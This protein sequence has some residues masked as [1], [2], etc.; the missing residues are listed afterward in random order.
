MINYNF[1]IVYL[2]NKY[3]TMCPRKLCELMDIKINFNFLEGENISIL[4]YNNANSQVYIFLSNNPDDEETD[5]L[6]AHE[7]SHYLLHPNC[8][9]HNIEIKS[10][11]MTNLLDSEANTLAEEILKKHN[12]NIKKSSEKIS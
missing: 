5:R 12:S 3:K 7:L 10:K 11:Y 6:I 1:I 2:F 8:Y 9:N 4:Y